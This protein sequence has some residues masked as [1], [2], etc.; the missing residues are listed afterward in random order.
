MTL[1]NRYR[2]LPARWTLFQLGFRALATAPAMLSLHPSFGV[3]RRARRSSSGPE[4]PAFRR[5]QEGGGRMGVAW[6]LH[7]EWHG[8]KHGYHANEVLYM[9]H[10]WI[11]AFICVAHNTSLMVVE[12]HGCMVA[13]VSVV[14]AWNKHFVVDHPAEAFDTHPADLK[15]AHFFLTLG[16]GLRRTSKV[17]RQASPSGRCAQ[18]YF[19]PWEIQLLINQFCHSRWF[20]Y[21]ETWKVCQQL[22]RPSNGVKIAKCQK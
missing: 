7:R 13:Q 14:R 21:H 15:T 17:K 11:V 19:L 4:G 6:S 20:I 12:V 3:R 9:V 5:P 1:V 8:K 10:K 2:P 16:H 22:D 18:G